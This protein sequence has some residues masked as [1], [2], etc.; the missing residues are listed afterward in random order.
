[1]IKKT[2]GQMLIEVLVGLV[3]IT[4][5]LVSSMVIIVHA[6]KLSRVARNRLES[7]KYA[8]QALEFLRNT[9]DRDSGAFFA[10]QSCGTCGPFAGGVYTCA[11]STCTFTQMPSP[12]RADVTVTISWDDG[13]STMSTNVSTVLTK[14]NL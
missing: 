5:A 6:T 13:G 9:R 1:M 11:F 2:S 7:A 4:M 12:T 10:N 8:E 3:V 14:Y